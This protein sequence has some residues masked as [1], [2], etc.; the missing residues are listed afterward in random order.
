[1]GSLSRLLALT[2]LRLAG[3]A[4]ADRSF[5]WKAHRRADR[6]GEGAAPAIRVQS[7]VPTGTTQ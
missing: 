3:P 1:M 2:L 7:D 5:L 4:R 6:R